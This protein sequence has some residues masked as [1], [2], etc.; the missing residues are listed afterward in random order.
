MCPPALDRVKVE[1]RRAVKQAKAETL[2]TAVKA[3]RAAAECEPELIKQD[4]LPSSSLYAS[5]SDVGKNEFSRR[6]T[7]M[8]PERGRQNTIR[9][10]NCG[11]LGHIARFCW[12]KESRNGVT[13]RSRERPRDREDVTG[14]LGVLVEP[15]LN[16]EHELLVLKGTVNGVPVSC[17]IDS[18]ACHNFFS[19]DLIARVGCTTSC[20]SDSLCIN[21][22]D[23]R[24]GMLSREQATIDLRFTGF[25]DNFTGVVAPISRY[26][27]I[28]GK[29]WLYKYNPSIDFRK[30]HVDFM[31]G[32]HAGNTGEAPSSESRLTEVMEVKPAE[33]DDD[34][35]LFFMTAKAARKAIQKGADWY[36]VRV[37]DLDSGQ[38]GAEINLLNADPAIGVTGPRRD[39]LKEL[40]QKHSTTLAKELPARLPPLRQV[41][42]E[43]DVEP[44]CTIILTTIDALGRANWQEQALLLE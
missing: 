10:F 9:C 24:K 33:S 36:V 37:E 6:P 35:E 17:L 14:E 16:M 11:R 30:N 39:E 44:G 34:S 26:E 38:D 25:C 18:G 43:I 22:A 21:L 13:R 1:L 2:Q 42:H 5:E 12:G 7:S 8:A 23:G 19:N 31:D 32:E 41:N 4:E 3:A 28:L 27:V 29:P 20:L 40:L 15:N